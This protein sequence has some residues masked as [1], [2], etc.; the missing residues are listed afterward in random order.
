ML[1]SYLD[2]RK[3]CIRCGIRK[4]I[5]FFKKRSR[6]YPQC[7]TCDSIARSKTVNHKLISKE[8]YRE[9]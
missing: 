3:E 8:K 9:S 5:S 1:G 7:V 4:H 6:I 2:F